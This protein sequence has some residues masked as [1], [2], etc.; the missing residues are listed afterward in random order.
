MAPAQPEI[1]LWDACSAMN[2][3]L[4]RPKPMEMYV[5][6]Q[7]GEWTSHITL[8]PS[9]NP[10]VKSVGWVQPGRRGGG[11]GWGVSL[12]LILIP[13]LLLLQDHDRRKRA[14]SHST[15]S[16]YPRPPPPRP[17]SRSNPRTFRGA[18]MWRT[19]VT[20]SPGSPEVRLGRTSAAAPPAFKRIRLGLWHHLY[21]AFMEEQNRRKK[22]SHMSAVSVLLVLQ[23]TETRPGWPVNGWQTLR[24]IE[25]PSVE[26]ATRRFNVLGFNNLWWRR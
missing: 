17:Q 14:R 12:T 4:G 3:P 2:A 6:H 15:C 13:Q 24:P 7:R 19:T 20:G 11:G 5:R 21:A 16:F 1:P 8:S 26:L 23:N 10:A 25:R 22:R 18:Q 9:V